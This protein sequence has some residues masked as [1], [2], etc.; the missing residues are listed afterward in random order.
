MSEPALLLHVQEIDVGELL[1]KT[2]IRGPL[3]IKRVQ[4]QEVIEPCVRNR[5]DDDT[6][7]TVHLRG[8]R[9]NAMAMRGTAVLAQDRGNGSEKAAGKGSGEAYRV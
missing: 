9:S 7:A 5:R 1:Q 8:E 6:V 2:W 3:A 4:L